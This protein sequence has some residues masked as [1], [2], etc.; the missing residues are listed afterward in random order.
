M[1]IWWVCV[2]VRDGVDWV[3][4]SQSA[5]NHNQ[6]HRHMINCTHNYAAYFGQYWYLELVSRTHN[7]ALLFLVRFF[8]N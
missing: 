7:L 4:T 6:Q 2:G 3:L 8:L 5:A 1:N